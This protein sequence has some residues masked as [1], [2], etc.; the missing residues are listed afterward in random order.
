MAETAR[1]EADEVEAVEDLGGHCLG[2][3]AGK[4]EPGLT[5]TAGVGQ[6]D[7]TSHRRLGGRDPGDRDVDRASARIPVVQWYAQGRALLARVSNGPRGGRRAG[8]P[9]KRRAGR[10][11]RGLTARRPAALVVAE[12]STAAAATMTVTS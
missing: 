2:Q 9:R 3:P 5:R 10:L 11:A 1:I 8:A 12:A 7:A 4:V 6:Q